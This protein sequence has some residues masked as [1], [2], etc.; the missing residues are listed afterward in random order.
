MASIKKILAPTDFS[1]LSLKALNETKNLAKLLNAEVHVMHV[2]PLL[3][4]AL[5]PDVV[6]DDPEFERKLKEKLDAGSGMPE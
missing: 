2:C 1:K 6:P 3:M 5:A 4:Y